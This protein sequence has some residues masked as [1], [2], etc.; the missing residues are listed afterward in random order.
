M[1]QTRIWIASLA[2]AL[3]ALAGTASAADIVAGQHYKEIV[4][5]Q[6]KFKGDA[7]IEVVE[8]FWYGCPHCHR[9]RPFMEEWLKTKPANVTYTRMPAVLRPSW[10]IHAR[11]YFTAEALGVADETH[12]ALFNAI[13][14]NKR[15][16]NTED[17]L[18][19]FYA[20]HGVEKDKFLKAFNSFAVESKL[21]RATEL[22][23]R[24]GVFA[25]PTVVI[26]GK[27]RT[28]GTMSEKGFDGMIETIDYLVKKES[29]GKS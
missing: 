17:E 9:F 5:E 11:A 18:A 20:E 27:Y 26:N 24:Y 2:L 28:D 3:L 14:V 10:A 21:R 6:P 25:T 1:K 4:P 15:R 12:D 29:E 13:H 19:E 22:A 8:I 7:K 23:R 16:L